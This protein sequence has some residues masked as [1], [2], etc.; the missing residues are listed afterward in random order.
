MRDSIFCH[1]TG[2]GITQV[3]SLNQKTLEKQNE[4]L[5]KAKVS[6]DK[7]VTPRKFIEDAVKDA[8][9]RPILTTEQAKEWNPA[10]ENQV[11]K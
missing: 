4:I 7:L 9:T 8:F 11:A 1:Y 2:S 3:F 5:K 6:E 10:L